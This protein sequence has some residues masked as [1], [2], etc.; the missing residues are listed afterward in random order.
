MTHQVFKSQKIIVLLLSFIF[1]LKLTAQQANDKDN[2]FSPQEI[3]Q[4]GLPYIQ[5]FSPKDYGGNPQ[6]WG[7]VEG[8]NGFIYVANASGAVLEYDGNNWDKI[9]LSNNSIVRSLAKSQEG[10]IYVGG[11]GEFGYLKKNSLGKTQYHSLSDK[12]DDEVSAFTNIWSIVTFQNSVF[13][14]CNNYLFSWDGDNLKV[15]KPKEK[16]GNV[17]KVHNRIYIES[18]GVGI[19]ELKGESLDLIQK[20]DTFVNEK[21]RITMMQPYGKNEILFAHSY[22]GLFTYNG[23]DMHV[24]D[25]NDSS[26]FKENPIYAGT[27]LSNEHYAIATLNSG[28][29]ILNASTGRIIRRYGKKQGLISDIAYATYGSSDG[30]IWIASDKGISRIDLTIPLRNF[31]EINGLTER[32]RSIAYDGNTI[33][34]ATKGVLKLEYN[35]LRKL[36]EPVFGKIE[37]IEEN[38][39]FIVPFE[40][41][42][43]VFQGEKVFSIDS[44]NRVDLLRNDVVL[45]YALK[46][47]IY[48]NFVYVSSQNGS[49]FEYRLVNNNWELRELINI[50]NEIVMIVEEANGDLWLGTYYDGVHRYKSKQLNSINSKN[51]VQKFD[52]ISGLYSMFD[53]KPFISD[54]GELFVSS[55]ED[56][57]YKFNT[58]TESF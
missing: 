36:M 17:Y 53:N 51:L 43:L 24:V 18:K 49:L 44:D 39:R 35:K 19:L 1:C 23:K 13:F 5:N 31:N 4:A 15:W 10:I 45:R 38:V 32:V 34:V 41:Q 27:M 46:S 9:Y 29:Y 48:P 8:E 54:E 12:L 37:G 2:S 3:W 7:F 21:G 22:I 25:K 14:A 58:K 52:T 30:A 47:K 55:T 57:I 56:G 26:V 28:V 50:G 6:N 16:F 20:G 11:I 42:K 33:F 40:S